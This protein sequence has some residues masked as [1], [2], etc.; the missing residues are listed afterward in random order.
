MDKFF[1][2]LFLPDGQMKPWQGTICPLLPFEPADFEICSRGSMFHIV[3]G[4]HS[5]GRYHR[6]GYRRPG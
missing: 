5:Q 4:Q 6:N 2:C 3:L 1:T